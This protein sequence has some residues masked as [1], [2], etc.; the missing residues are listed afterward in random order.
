MSLFR[1]E[2]IPCDPP[3]HQGGEVPQ[4]QHII[5][6]SQRNRICGRTQQS[7]PS[8]TR[9]PQYQYTYPIFRLQQHQQHR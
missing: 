1:E 2:L 5:G 6:W 4:P 3:E 9:V 8:S 7:L